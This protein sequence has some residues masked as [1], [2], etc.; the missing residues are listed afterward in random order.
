M[1]VNGWIMNTLSVLEFANRRLPH[2]RTVVVR[3]VCVGSLVLAKFAT[4]SVRSQKAVSARVRGEPFQCKIESNRISHERWAALRWHA[5][6]AD[7]MTARADGLAKAK[8]HACS[9]NS[10][11]R[12]MEQQP[13]EPEGKPKGG[14]GWINPIIQSKIAWRD[15]DVVVSVP[16]KSGTTW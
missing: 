9:F 11:L 3:C 12:T 15:D 1:I 7:Q 4:S 10:I 6:R 13:G 16:L 5:T 14:A 8:I 2:R